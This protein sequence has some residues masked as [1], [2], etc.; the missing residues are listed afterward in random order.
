MFKIFKDLVFWWMSVLED[1][2]FND[3]SDAGSAVIFM[4]LGFFGPIACFFLPLQPFLLKLFVSI[5]VYLAIGVLTHFSIK[6]EMGDSP[7]FE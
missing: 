3:S 6:L 1:L 4:I 7:I 2:M 5:S